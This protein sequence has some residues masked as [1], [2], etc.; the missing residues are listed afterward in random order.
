MRWKILWATVFAI[1][2]AAFSLTNANP[3]D[4]TLW[5]TTVRIRL[6]FVIL[7]SVL[8]GMILM[9]ILWSLQAWKLRR[10][11]NELTKYVH[12]LEQQLEELQTKAAQALSADEETS[13][14]HNRILDESAD[15]E[16]IQTSKDDVSSN[17]NRS[18]QS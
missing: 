18:K 10:R 14:E 9:A 1:I 5:V 4:L 6:V 2:I 15:Q 7:I 12:S 13:D 11:N 16:I 17:A 3:V 8:L